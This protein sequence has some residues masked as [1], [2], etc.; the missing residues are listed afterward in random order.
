MI[1][2]L[3]EEEIE[4]LETYFDPIAMSEILFSDYDNLSLM[5]DDKLSH[6]RLG[7]ISLLSFEYL[8]D[9]DNSDVSREIRKENFLL[10]KSAGEVFC[11]GGRLFGK[12]MCVLKLDLFLSLIHYIGEKIGFS[13]C[14]FLHLKGVLEEVC[15]ALGQHLFFDIFEPQINRSPYRIAMKNGTICDGI[16]MNIIGKSPGKQF[17]AKHFSK[18]FIEEASQ[19]TD[20]VFQ[21]RR[22]SVS[23]NGCIYR[24]SGMTDFTIHS[25][26]GQVFSPPVINKKLQTRVINLPQTINPNWDQSK[27]EEAIKDFGGKNS[28]G[29]RINVEGEVVEEGISVID[30]QRVRSQYN[31][32]RKLKNFE[33]TKKSFH[34]YE[35]L[36]ILER[37]R[38]AEEVWI[39]SDIGESAPTEITVFFKIKDKYRYVYNITLYGLTDKEQ[40]KIFRFVFQEL[41]GTYCGFDTSEGTGRS[42][43]RSMIEIFNE[44]SMI[45][46]SFSSKISVDYEKTKAG[47]IIFEKGEP[48]YKEE[49]VSDW[50]IRHLRDMLYENKFELPSDGKLDKQLN[51]I[52]A[53][54]ATTK[55]I[56]KCIYSDDHLLQS[57]QVMAIMDWKKE[58]NLLKPL[59]NKK[60]FKS[61]VG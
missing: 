3:S 30:M 15:T 36:L 53:I 13:S 17:F 59:K 37:A 41:D 1:E 8:I 35:N 44:E 18:L 54:R 52:R 9:D 25:P 48:L 51:G 46:V 4:F 5:Q 50:S 20:E 58:F 2:S 28:L 31:E 57:Y 6:V 47:D 12:T 38:N 61:G 43:Y 16:N 39:A 34:N 10:R 19:E 29:Y 40:F 42:I 27:K 49:D 26:A 45:D 7:Q 60:F 22:D 33:I 21:K 55:I 23:E 32:D 14:D 11:F 24:I 56:Y